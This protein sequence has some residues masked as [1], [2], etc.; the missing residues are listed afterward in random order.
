M[1]YTVDSFNGFIE[2]SASV[3]V[4]ELLTTSA[5]EDISV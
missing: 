5:N 1:I 4:Q 3:T 2:P